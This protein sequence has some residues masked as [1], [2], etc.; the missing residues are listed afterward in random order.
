MQVKRFEPEWLAGTSVGEVMFQA[1]YHLK[2][3]S[4]GA[5]QQPVI[6]MKSCMEVGDD[7]VPEKSWTGREWFVVRKAEMQI[8]ED[9]VL[10]PA[11][12]L[13][14]EAREQ[15]RGGQV[16]RILHQ[17][18]R[19]HRR[20]QGRDL[21]AAR[22]CKGF[23]HG[24]VLAGIRHPFGRAVVQPRTGGV[25][26][27][28]YGGTAA[29]ERPLLLPSLGAGRRA[30]FVGEGKKGPFSDDV[31]LVR[32]CGLRHRSLPLRGRSHGRW[33][34]LGRRSPVRGESRGHLR[35]R[36]SDGAG[37]SAVLVVDGDERP[38]L[39]PG[40][41]PAVRPPQRRRRPPRRPLALR[42]LAGPPGGAAGGVCAVRAAE[43]GEPHRT[44][45]RCGSELGQVQSF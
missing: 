6:G 3:L 42:G 5:Y 31:R 36:G 17:K 38:G 23:D 11:L 12:T 39:R 30:H 14:V 10:A 34:P 28:L 25:S 32:G 2:E 22:G 40:P 44:P 24:K 13:G 26:N 41:R 37:G 27:V 33:Q 35:A 43:S 8:S 9:G 18:L 16:R 29:V 19:P 4:M 20:A 7:T 1:D 15:I 45:T 21:P